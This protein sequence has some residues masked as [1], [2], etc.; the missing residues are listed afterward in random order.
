MAESYGSGGAKATQHV[1]ATPHAVIFTLS[2][3]QHQQA[4]ACLQKSGK[5][6]FKFEEVS[7][8]ELPFTLAGHRIIVD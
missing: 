6:T 1:V 3:E 4:R 2:E 5:A 8:S 7:V